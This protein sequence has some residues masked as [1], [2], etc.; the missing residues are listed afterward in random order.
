[1]V[2]LLDHCIEQL[3]QSIQC[4]GDL[5]PVPLLPYGEE[6]NITLIGNPQLHTC[7]SWD[8]FRT[9]WTDRGRTN[10]SIEGLDS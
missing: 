6:P 9:W 3:R 4:A 10:G 7:R 5:T 2:E 8:S 1:M